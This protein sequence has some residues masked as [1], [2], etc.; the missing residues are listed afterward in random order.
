MRRKERTR[1]ACVDVSV[2]LGESLSQKVRL[3]KAVFAKPGLPNHA[4]RRSGDAVLPNGIA[5]SSWGTGPKTALPDS[6]TLQ[7]ACPAVWSRF[8]GGEGLGP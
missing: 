2:S 8:L 5:H 6:D 4:L 7:K 3:P 1:S